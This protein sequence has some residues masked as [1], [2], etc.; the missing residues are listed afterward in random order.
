MA[1][2]IASVQTPLNTY[3]G[4]TTTDRISAAERLNAITEA[5]IWLQEE[6]ENDLQVVTYPLNYFDGVHY[7]KVTT[8]LADLLEGADLRRAE[9]DQYNSFT[10]K[11]SRELA[12]EIGQMNGES[13]WAIERRDKDAYLVVNHESKYQAEVMADMDSTTSGGG[14]WT[15]DSTNS[16]ATNLTVDSV[17]FT[18]GSGSLNFDVDVSQSGNNKATISNSTLTSRDLS[19]YVDLGSFLLDVYIPD[20]TYTSSITII[21]GSS[22]SAYWSATVTTDISGSALS[23][24]W[25][26]V[27]VNWADATMT[28]TPSASAITYIALTVNYSASQADDTDYRFDNLRIV[29]AETLKFYYLSWYVGTNSGGTDITTFGATTDIPYYSG[30]YDNYIYPVAH[31]AAEVLFRSMR[32]HQDADEQEAEAKDTLKRLLR[33]HPQSKTPESKS[34]KVHGINFRRRR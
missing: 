19:Q 16:D 29:R 6:L 11:S 10:H 8:S 15:V 33:I 34:F 23:D 5:T 2:T 26:T 17:E 13:S 12:E 3:I 7:Y 1:V 20:H 25:N 30:Q 21:W 18:Q 9:D 24:G 4:D 32:L 22:T 27:K 14:T 28:S 31:K